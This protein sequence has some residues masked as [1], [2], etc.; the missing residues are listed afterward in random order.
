M[1]PRR[2]VL[3]DDIAP[4][5]RTLTSRR[6]F[7]L[8]PIVRYSMGSLLGCTGARRTGAAEDVSGHPRL[9]AYGRFHEPPEPIP[10]HNRRPT[11]RHVDSSAEECGLSHLK[12]WYTCWPYSRSAQQGATVGR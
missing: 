1:L 8:V 10:A 6:V 5:L 12:Y 4:R 3:P 7:G 2:W 9:E 11:G